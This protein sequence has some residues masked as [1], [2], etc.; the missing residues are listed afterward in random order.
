M[1]YFYFC[2]H[3]ILSIL[4]ENGSILAQSRKEVTESIRPVIELSLMPNP[5]AAPDPPHCHFILHLIVP[6]PILFYRPASAFCGMRFVSVY[7]D[8]EEPQEHSIRL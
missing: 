4:I 7:L 3:L 1:F 5:Y 2:K 6:D 8:Q